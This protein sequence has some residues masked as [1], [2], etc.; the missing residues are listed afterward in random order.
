M[1]IRLGFYARMARRGTARDEASS[2]GLLEPDGERA[3]SFRRTQAFALAAQHDTLAPIRQ[4]LTVR[5]GEVEV[6]RRPDLALRRRRRAE[7]VCQ[8]AE[9]GDPAWRE[10]VNE[11][12]SVVTEARQA[13]TDRAPPALIADQ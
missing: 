10:A 5:A 6:E 4:W 7:H 2:S 11:V 9:R 13:V 1:Y 12:L 3:P 8:N